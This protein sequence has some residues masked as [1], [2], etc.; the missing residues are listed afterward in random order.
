[1]I[2]EI[3][4]YTFLF[5]DDFSAATI[6]SFK[7]SIKAIIPE[8]FLVCVCILLLMYGV[9]RSTGSGRSRGSSLVPAGS[10]AA[11]RTW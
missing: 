3:D 11:L 8:L 2:E 4:F 1:M 9:P 10:S 7:A 5:E 6:I